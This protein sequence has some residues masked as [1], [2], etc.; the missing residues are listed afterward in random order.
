MGYV[1]W[2]GGK[3][4]VEEEETRTFESQI[5][6]DLRSLGAIFYC[7]TSLPQTLLVSVDCPVKS[8]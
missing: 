6:T 3:L 5:V 7:K 2:I 1:G 4:G 8:I